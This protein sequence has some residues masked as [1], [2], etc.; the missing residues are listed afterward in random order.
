MDQL[1]ENGPVTITADGI[2]ALLPLRAYHPQF[3]DKAVNSL[4]SQTSPDWELKIIVERSDAG[5]FEDV[6]QHALQ[7]SRIDLVINRGRKL[8][9][10]IN[11]GMSAATTDFVALLLGDDEWAPQAIEVLSGAIQRHPDSDFFHSSRRYI[12]ET[13]AFISSIYQ[14]RQNVTLADFRAGTPVKHLLCWRRSLAMQFGGLDESLN[15]VGPDDFDFPWTMA[16]HGAVFQSVDECLY[17]YRE[18]DECFRL[19]TE[20]PRSLHEKEIQRVLQKHGLTRDEI[21]AWI[22]SGRRSYLQQCKYDSQWQ[23]WFYR[24]TNRTRRMHRPT[25]R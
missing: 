10:A 18:H 5:K 19:T 24:L 13:G 20:L 23:R 11:S 3:L 21:N 4:L 1:Q 14:S 15:S 17:H 16:E 2:T 12:D 9:G 22:E 25:Y 6:L 8:A 7:D